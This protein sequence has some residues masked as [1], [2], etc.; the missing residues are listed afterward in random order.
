MGGG[1]AHDTYASYAWPQP[2]LVRVGLAAVAVAL[3]FKP[4][5]AAAKLRMAA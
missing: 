3:T 5:P 4:V 1:W 2:R